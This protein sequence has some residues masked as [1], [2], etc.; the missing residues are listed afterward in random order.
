[1]FVLHH[2]LRCL[3]LFAGIRVLLLALEEAAHPVDAAGAGAGVA[4]PGAGAADERQCCCFLVLAS[5]LLLSRSLFKFVEL[6]LSHSLHCSPFCTRLLVKQNHRCEHGAVSCFC[7][8]CGNYCTG[9]IQANDKNAT[10]AIC[11]VWKER[12]GSLLH[13][14]E[15]LQEQ[16]QLP[17]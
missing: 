15:M 9:S 3:T 16:F 14:H 12:L 10:T 4:H 17:R 6:L 7:V 5:V 11:N 8:A 2:F 13:A 1:V